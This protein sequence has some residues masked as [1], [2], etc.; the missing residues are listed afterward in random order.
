MPLGEI[1]PRELSEKEKKWRKGW[2]R[3]EGH[4]LKDM[5]PTLRHMSRE[6]YLAWTYTID[7]RLALILATEPQFR[8]ILAYQKNKRWYHEVKDWLW[9][10]RYGN[11]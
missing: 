5:I 11:C 1:K 8:D 2:M 9:R 10:K 3:W 4:E 6:E 7:P